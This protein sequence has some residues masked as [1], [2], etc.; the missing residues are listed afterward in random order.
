MLGLLLLAI[1]LSGAW[2]AIWLLADL[3]DSI[4]DPWDFLLLLAVVEA[5]M[6]FCL[7]WLPRWSVRR[8]H[9]AD[10]ISW[11]LPTRQD[12]LSATL[13]LAL[14]AAIWAAYVVI[15]DQAGWWWIAPTDPPA[16]WSAFPN[17]TT[18]I[19]YGFAAVVLA[20]WIEETFFRGFALGGLK[21]VW[22]LTPALL[23]SA[24]LFSAMHFDIYV[25]IPFALFGLILGWL[26]LRTNHLTAPAMAHAGW[27]LGVTVLLLAEYGVG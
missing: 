15:G 25:A 2:I 16:D 23:V 12:W 17:W 20:P 19:I 7:V 21:R 13:G 8:H 3:G 10:A 4:G 24:A 1:V 11:R 22:W 14:M 18:A 26:Y 5:L 6:A 27:N 9:I